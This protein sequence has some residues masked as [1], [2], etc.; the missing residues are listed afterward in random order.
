MPEFA[1]NPSAY[2][3]ESDEPGAFRTDV[4]FPWNQYT[5]IQAALS[6]MGEFVRECAAKAAN[7]AASRI[8]ANLVDGVAALVTLDRSE[9]EK[10]I[11][12]TATAT[13]D[14][15]ASRVSISY[16]SEPLY[17]FAN[18]EDITGTYS[19]VYRDDAAKLVPAAFIATMQSGLRGIFQRELID[20]NRD[21]RL[22]IE[23]KFGPSVQAIVEIT[24]GFWNEQTLRAEYELSIAVDE[25]R[26]ELVAWFT[27]H[28]TEGQYLYGRFVSRDFLSGGIGSTVAADD[29]P[30]IGY[31]GIADEIASDIFSPSTLIANF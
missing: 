7:I 17:S 21:G 28:Q 31:L 14:R 23:E 25:V 4:N 27:S 16:S 15:P 5:N 20:G 18:Y 11:Q 1:I 24:P 8:R 3:D 10:L 13:P 19:Q 12:I 22:P 29:T 30:G 9:I 6:E 26:N 2:G